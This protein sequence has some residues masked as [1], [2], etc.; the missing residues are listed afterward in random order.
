MKYEL[1]K[2]NKSN[3]E[4]TLHV[5]AK[6]TD[7]YKEKVLRGFQKEVDVPGF[8][9]GHVPLSMVESQVRPEYIKIGIYEEMIHEGINLIIK[10]KGESEVRFIWN[11]Y[12]LNQEEKK[13]TLT[14]TFKIDSYPEVEVKNQNWKK[15][16]VKKIDDKVSAKE[17]EETMTNLRRQQATYKD[18]DVVA[19]DVVIK[20]RMKFLDKKGTELDAGSVFIG[21][22]EFDE[23]AILKTIFQKRK[24]NETFEIEYNHDELPHIMHYH[25]DDKKPAKM[26]I[27]IVE[28]K[29]MELPEFDDAAVKKMFSDE[30]KTVK[31]LEER[32]R[33]VTAGQKY[34]AGL[35][36]AIEDLIQ[37]VRGS[38]SISI[39][40][41][42]V[43]QEAQARTN[44]FKERMWGEEAMK[45]Y[46]QN[47]GEEKTKEFM[48]NMNEASTTSL[49]KYFIL[50]KFA[51]L[52][53]VNDI[54]WEKNM[55][56][57]EKI[58]QKVLGEEKSTTPKKS[59]T[60]AES[61]TKEKKS[62]AKE[63]KAPVKAKTAKKE[64]TDAKPVK[65]PA[66]KKK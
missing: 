15:V 11:I 41:S 53:E 7:S 14:I 43:E 51:E 40:Q 18:T 60:K 31:E 21:N 65:K 20:A 62:D 66:A 64:T 58:Y 10:E 49:E 39:P 12:D 32:I 25:K 59:E 4:I 34:Q 37:S 6:N 1:K 44:S 46:F 22:E 56:A 8:R 19:R 55:D 61:K 24:I 35:V 38:L 47:M 29:K 2:W 27:T 54:N 3:Y 50:R 48:T 5:D 63:E 52:L 26:S 57:E 28:L 33:E 9:K 30:V 17:I 23:H 42:M 16:S 13:D 36:Q 45:K